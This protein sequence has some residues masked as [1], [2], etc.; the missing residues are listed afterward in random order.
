[1]EPIGRA[2]TRLRRT[3]DNAPCF[4]VKLDNDA[5]H[6]DDADREHRKLEPQRHALYDVLCHVVFRDGKIGPVQPQLRVFGKRVEEAAD[7]ADELREHGRDGRTGHTPMEAEDE[8]KIE[9][10]I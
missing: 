9:S 10:D 5:L 3:R 4:H 8:Q 2:K 7:G 1:M 6:R